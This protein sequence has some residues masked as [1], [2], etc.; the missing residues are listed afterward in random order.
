MVQLKKI[1]VGELFP[2]G[3]NTQDIVSYI[4]GWVHTH[5]NF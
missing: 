5:R 4:T 1:G 2:P 3:T